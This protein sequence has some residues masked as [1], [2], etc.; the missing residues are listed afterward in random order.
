M[1]GRCAA[2]GAVLGAVSPLVTAGVALAGTSTTALGASSVDTPVGIGAVA[3]GVLGLI[4]GLV[5]RRRSAVVRAE[6]EQLVTPVVPPVVPAV[7]PA[8]ALPA[9]AAA[10]TAAQPTGA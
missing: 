6:S 8:V 2:L 1:R 4:A 5:R 10:P 7:V 3:L 9:P